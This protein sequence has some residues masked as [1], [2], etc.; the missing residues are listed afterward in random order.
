MAGKKNQPSVSGAAFSSKVSE[1]PLI[2]GFERGYRNREDITTLPVGIL[3]EGSQNVLTNTYRRVGIVK[4]YVLD[5]QRDTSGNP[6]LSGYDWARHIGDERHLRAGFAV[7]EGE[8]KLQYRYVASEGER[9]GAVTFTEGQVYWIDL[10]TGLGTAVS[11]SLLEQADTTDLI[12]QATS[13]DLIELANGGSSEA[14]TAEV[15][16]RFAEFWDTTELLSMLLFV[17]TTSNIFMWTGGVATV[18]STTANTITKTGSRTWAQEGFIVGA[19]YAREVVINGT[20]YT[21]T[22]GADSNTLTGV[23]PDPSA[24]PALSVTHQNV[25]T[26]ANSAI[27]GLPDAFRNYIIQTLD[28]QVYVSADNDNSVYVSKTS[29]FKDF[30]F[31]SPREVGEGA[32]L[33]LDGVPTAMTSQESQMYISAGKDYWYTTEFTLAADNTAQ[34]LSVNRLKTTARQAAMSQEAT[35]KIKNNIFYISYEPIVNKLGVEQNYLLSPQANDLSFPIVNDISNYDLD[36]CSAYFDQKFGYVCV[37][38]EGLL[39]IYNMT[40]DGKLDPKTGT[41][42]K[43]HYWEAPI[44]Y[45]MKQLAV[46]DGEL[47]GHSYQSSNTFK[48][49]EGYEFDGNVYEAV[50]AFSYNDSGSRNLTKTS[51]SAFVEGYITSNTALTLTIQDELTGG[52]TR[53]FQIL[54]SD[55]AIVQQGADVASLGKD[56]LGK[57]VFGG[58]DEFLEPLTNPPKFRVYKTYNPKPYFEEQIRFS[59]IGKNQVWEI[60]SFGTNAVVSTALP[61]QITQ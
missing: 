35:S 24:E 42:V 10:M 9:Y 50:A 49:F 4:G 7:Q 13:T 26:T 59:S 47:Y 46:I 51:T 40:D 58:E 27:A 20:V 16:F 57:H 5:G 60:V 56:S 37:P 61:T 41:L 3:V 44:G 28:N 45:A 12:E 33:T 31:S 11:P 2:T 43:N 54:G 53:E 6:I 38:K 19:G 29:D 15:R 1:F 32:I 25:V 23:T 14:S 39:R 21:Y 17:N 18:A 30:S 8:G 55:T 36:D 48:L 52:T 22:G 34:A